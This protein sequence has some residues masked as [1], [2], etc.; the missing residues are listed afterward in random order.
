[1]LE[2]FVEIVR[3]GVD[4]EEVPVLLA[5][6]GPDMH[7]VISKC[8]CGAWHADMRILEEA[9]DLAEGATAADRQ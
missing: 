7:R 9:L 1:M 4:M 2:Y 3:L 8:M 5:I 6:D